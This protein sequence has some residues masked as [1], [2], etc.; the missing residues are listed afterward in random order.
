M[1]LV[2]FSPKTTAYQVGIPVTMR[3]RNIGGIRIGNTLDTMDL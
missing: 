3:R 2:E 1:E